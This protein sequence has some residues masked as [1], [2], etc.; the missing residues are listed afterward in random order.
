[1]GG[2]GERGPG[3]LVDRILEAD[4]ITDRMAGPCPEAQQDP[5]GLPRLSSVK[6]LYLPGCSPVPKSKFNQKSKKT[7]KQRETVKQAGT[8]VSWL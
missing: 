4:L 7:Q 3:I 8:V 5:W 2:A 6:D 1:M